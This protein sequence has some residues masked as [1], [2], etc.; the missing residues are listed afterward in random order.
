MNYL[1]N[2]GTQLQIISTLL[3]GGWAIYQDRLEIGGVVAFI[4]GIGKITDPWGDL[5][6]YFRDASLSQVRYA[7]VR[8]ALSQ[9]CQS[10][11]KFDPGS[12][13]N[14]DPFRRWSGL[15]PVANRRAPRGAE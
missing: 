6:Y 7:L 1:M 15:V 14:V 10:A 2:L 11:L 5:I 12:A 9:Q 3:V 13:P 8:D 4:S